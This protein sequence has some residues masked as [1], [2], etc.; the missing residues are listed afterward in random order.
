MSRLCSFHTM[1]RKNGQKKHESSQKVRKWAE[2]ARKLIES[3]KLARRSNKVERNSFF[4]CK[5]VTRTHKRNCDSQPQLS[6]AD[7]VYQVEGFGFKP[8]TRLV[9]FLAEKNAYCCLK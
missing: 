1:D 7:R 9:T 6:S 2:E 5:C 3:K 4:F 8:Q